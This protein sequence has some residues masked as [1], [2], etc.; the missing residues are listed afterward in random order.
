MGSHE[1]RAEYARRMHRVLEHIDRH[2]DQ[3]LALDDLAAVAHF[4]AF[5]FHRLFSAWMSETLGEYLR[6]RRLEVAALRLVSQPDTPVLHVA[7]AVGFGSA[8]AFARAFKSRFGQS[9]SSWRSSRRAERDEQV[10]KPHQAN[11]KPGQATS[12]VDGDD[13]IWRPRAQEAS[14]KVTLIDRQPARVAYLT[15]VGPYGPAIAEFWQHTVAPW[16]VTNNLLDRPRYGISHDDPGITRSEKCRYDAGVEVPTDFVGAGSHL[17]TVIP[18]GRCAV[19]RFKGTAGDIVD[20]W[21]VLLRDWLPE[22]GLQLD[23]RPFFEYYPLGTSYDPTTGVFDC[24]L[25]IPVAVL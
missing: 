19:T 22:S 18:G 11:R 17:I 20:A 12:P 16:M 23:S 5:H 3:P 6:R 4:S 14:M 24:D 25:V 7:L 8:E 2:L 9:P 13:G 21:A 10:R 15:Y 1:S